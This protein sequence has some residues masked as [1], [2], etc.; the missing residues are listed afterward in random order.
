MYSDIAIPFSNEYK[1]IFYFHTWYIRQTARY[2]I[3][4]T[5]CRACVL[6]RFH[7]SWTPAWNIHLCRNKHHS[8]LPLQLLYSLSTSALTHVCLKYRTEDSTSPQLSCGPGLT[9]ARFAPSFPTKITSLGL[10]TPP[11]AA[12]I[13]RRRWSTIHASM[14]LNIQ[15]LTPGKPCI[16][17]PRCKAV[18]YTHLYFL[19]FLCLWFLGFK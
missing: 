11:K 12:D 9:A 5:L 16:P 7:H 8:L 19:L 14:P 10:A 18:S 4:W 1:L 6:Y 13:T 2:N 3:S 17:C 15:R